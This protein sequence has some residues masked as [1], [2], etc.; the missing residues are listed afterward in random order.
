MV[1][2]TPDASSSSAGGEKGG[3]HAPGGGE[4]R[5]SAHSLYRECLSDRLLLIA[6]I[7]AVLILVLSALD[8]K[9]EAPVPTVLLGLTFLASE[10]FAIP[11]RPKGRISLALFVVMIAIMHTGPL[12]AAVIPLFGIPAFIYEAGREDLKRVMFNTAQYVVSAGCAALVFGHTGGRVLLKR[13][14]FDILNAIHSNQGG[15]VVLPW[16]LATVVF[17]VINTV[18][19]AAALARKEKMRTL[20]FWERRMLALFPG[21]L[22]YSGIGFLAAIAYSRVQFTSVALLATLLI[23]IRV[24]YTRYARMQD[25]CDQTAVAVIEAL[26]SAPSL[27]EGHSAGVAEIAVAIGEE[28]DLSDD[29]LHFLKIAALFHDVGKI[30]VDSELINKPGMLD[31]GEYEQI[32]RHPEVSASILSGE[33]SLA[34][35]SFAVIHHHETTDGCG[36]PDGISG[37]TIPHGARILAVA[38]AFDAMQRPSPYRKGLSAQAAVSEIVRSKG[39]QFDPEVVDAFVRV[40]LKR[41]IWEGALEEEIEEPSDAARDSVQATHK[42]QQTLESGEGIFEE[43]V[44]EQEAKRNNPPEPGAYLLTPDRIEK[45]VHEWKIKTILGKRKRRTFETEERKVGKEKK[46]SGKRE[47]SSE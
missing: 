33:K 25:V 18:F 29:D 19:I 16:L 1:E 41:G 4:S 38:D 35:V 7:F 40:A 22:L 14:S 23:G 5:G 6:A 26:E 37:E 12:G 15:K 43:V 47:N 8:T 13:E 45:D 24:V 9:V 2:E 36:Y 31:P 44:A 28:M 46:E 27:V 20:R 42:P 21:Y 10:L 39:I 32:K 11:L 30:S 34:G 3:T 17:F